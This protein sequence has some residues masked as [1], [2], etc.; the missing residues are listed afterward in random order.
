MSWWQVFSVKDQSQIAHQTHKTL[1]TLVQNK[2]MIQQFRVLVHSNP[3]CS[4]LD[5]HFSLLFWFWSQSTSLLFHVALE[6]QMLH[7][8]WIKSLR[9]MIKLTLESQG[10]MPSKTTATYQ[11]N[12][13]KSV[14]ETEVSL[15]SLRKWVFH[16]TTTPLQKPSSINWSKPS[17]SFL[18]LS[19]TLHPTWDFGLFLLLTDNSLKFS[20]T[21]LSRTMSV[22]IEVDLEVIVAWTLSEEKLSY[23]QLFTVSSY[24]QFSGPLHSQ[25]SCAW[26]RWNASCIALD[27]IGS[28]CRT[29]SSRVMVTLL[30]HSRH[31]RYCKMPSLIDQISKLD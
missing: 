28:R 4:V 10:T 3:Q 9:K 7:M 2:Q 25:S 20:S 8:T 13:N 6:T 22:F 26:T 23:W 15:Q 12:N 14:E 5:L 31:K 17:N 24:S 27:F 16:T 18:E 19:Q 30:N 21:W 29:S 11:L 1:A